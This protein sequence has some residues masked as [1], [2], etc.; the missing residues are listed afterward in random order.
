MTTFDR[1][2]VALSLTDADDGLL[3]YAAMLSR[4]LAWND[5]LFA[6]VAA[7]DPQPWLQRLG[8]QVRRVFGEPAASARA[9]GNTT[10]TGDVLSVCM[11]LLDRH[12]ASSVQ[13]RL[14]L[15]NHI[16]AQFIEGTRRLI[17]RLAS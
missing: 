3:R 16:V 15:A 13:E 1:P 11:M 9:Q 4:S 17:P 2:L 8:D 5:I 12:L 10:G 7:K 6:H 14:R